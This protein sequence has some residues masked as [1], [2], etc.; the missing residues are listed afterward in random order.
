M[1][2]FRLF[3]ILVLLTASALAV[4]YLRVESARTAYRI[5]RM[6]AELHQMHYKLWRQ[7]ADIAELKEP[8]RIQR[9]VAQERVQVDPPTLGESGQSTMGQSAWETD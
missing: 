9:L 5:H 3:V 1:R 7:D 2:P 6:H 8:N 4:V